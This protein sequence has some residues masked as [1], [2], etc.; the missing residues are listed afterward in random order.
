M[1]AR[2]VVSSTAST[3]FLNSLRARLVERFR[4]LT[5]EALR[6]YKVKAERTEFLSAF[7][8]ISY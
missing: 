8:F 7:V 6:L 3:I 1:F 2:S 5:A 4:V